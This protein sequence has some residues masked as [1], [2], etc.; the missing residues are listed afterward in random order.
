MNKV[1]AVQRVTVLRRL[2]LAMLDTSAQAAAVQEQHGGECDCWTCGA[3]KDVARFV[4]RI[5][6]DLAEN[7]PG[8]DAL[9]RFSALEEAE[10][11]SFRTVDQEK[12]KAAE[13]KQQVVYFE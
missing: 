11:P 10:D 7:T 2:I 5:G 8:L 9:N 12:L 6:P 4:A 13:L 1:T 3:A